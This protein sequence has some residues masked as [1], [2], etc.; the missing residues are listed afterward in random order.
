MSACRVDVTR[1][2]KKRFQIHPAASLRYDPE[3]ITNMNL[4]DMLLKDFA[5]NCI[6]VTD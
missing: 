1:Y 2:T 5:K 6:Y 4:G 3:I